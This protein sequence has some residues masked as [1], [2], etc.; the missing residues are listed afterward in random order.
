ME[1]LFNRSV[2]IAQ[3]LQKKI[4]LIIQYSLKDPQINTIITVSNVQLSRDLSYAK[5][6]V[7]F[8]QS[9][10]E[11]N[12]KKKIMILNK[13]TGYIRKLLCKKMRL[14]IVPNIIFCHD[15]SFLKGNKIS[16][17]LKNL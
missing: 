7:S 5:V 14:R 10:N 1:K 6:F 8:L 13:S 17:I 12:I 16:V 2:R 9:N 11:L 3:E 15:D 4:A